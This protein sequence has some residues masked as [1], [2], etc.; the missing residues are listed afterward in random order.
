MLQKVF[1][2]LSALILAG[3]F[4]F[5]TESIGFLSLRV[6]DFV[7][8]KFEAR[9]TQKID[10]SLK[11]WNSFEISFF[12]GL[13]VLAM[14]YF[15]LGIFR[16][17]FP[18]VVIFFPVLVFLLVTIFFKR[19]RILTDI[20]KTGNIRD[21]LFQKPIFKIFYGVLIAIIF[22]QSLR[23]VISFDALWYHIPIPKMFLQE[24]FIG[25]VGARM[26]Y[27]VHPFLNF[28]WNLW[29]LALPFSTALAGIVI[30]AVQAMSLILGISFVKK[31]H[32]QNSLK[33]FWSYFIPLIL[34]FSGGLVF[35]ALGQAYNDIYGMLFGLIAGLF[36]FNFDLNKE[37]NS[38]NNFIALVLISGLFLLKIFFGFF[39][40]FLFIYLFWV[41]FNSGHEEKVCSFKIFKFELSIT[42]VQ[43]NFLCLCLGCFLVLILPWFIRSYI[44][45]GRILDP[46]GRPGF[47]R[48][49]YVQ[50]GSSGPLNHYKNFVWQRFYTDFLNINLWVFSPLFLLGS[51]FPFLFQHKNFKTYF[52][53]WVVSFTGFWLVYFINIVGSFRY[54]LPQAMLLVYLGYLVLLQFLENQNILIAKR[55]S[56]F[57]IL[58]V[59]LWSGFS[60]NLDLDY[61]WDHKFQ[62]S[63]SYLTEWTI[64]GKP[65]SGYYQGKTTLKPDNLH[66]RDKIFLM[67]SIHK[68]AYIENPYD[69]FLVF[70]YDI[71]QIVDGNYESDFETLLN[72]LKDREIK[73]LLVS[74]KDAATVTDKPEEIT[75]LSDWCKLFKIR[76]YP[77]CLPQ[78]NQNFELILED[79]QQLANWYKVNY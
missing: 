59:F 36:I 5:I 53:L 29:P 11:I 21:I 74:S 67:G 12:L 15:F 26:S 14:I 24:N 78:N 76:D 22:W 25:F 64:R 43:L 71:N 20:F 23:P 17:I 73:Y 50:A 65:N 7:G 55:A 33:S 45:T 32:E 8:S 54:L 49:V 16:L 58:A 47:N 2:A 41:N 46:V 13:V 60:V 31:I 70:Y 18:L 48:Q 72:Y 40:V 52:N 9:H 68:Q 51:L 3:I 79:K 35:G 37:I 10:E 4:V 77:K 63:D 34:I 39:A 57:L 61:W 19:Y 69:D 62:N 56:V 6:F 28:F 75:N 42:K 66:P 44:F 1:E 27:S 30:N 38:K